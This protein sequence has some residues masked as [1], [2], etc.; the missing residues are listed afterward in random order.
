MGYR[1]YL[2]AV[3]T[4]MDHM[5]HI[6]RRAM[7]ERFPSGAA[8]DKTSIFHYFLIMFWQAETKLSMH[9]TSLDEWKSKAKYHVEAQLH[10]IAKKPLWQQ[11]QKTPTKQNKP[12]QKTKV[13]LIFTWKC[14]S[15]WS[16]S[17]FKCWV[18]VSFLRA[19]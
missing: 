5:F 16:L 7:K 2:I 17:C 11:Q 6:T 14:T 13:I 18:L 10:I 15:W 4:Y 1:C 12:N 19:L 8:S 9:L 3:S